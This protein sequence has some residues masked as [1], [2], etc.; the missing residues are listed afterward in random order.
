M[1]SLASANRSFHVTPVF[2]NIGINEKASLAE[3][4]GKTKPQEKSNLDNFERL[5]DYFNRFKKINDLGQSVLADE[6]GYRKFD[7]L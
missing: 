5:N 1:L 7:K 4:L 3:G 6:S 2:F